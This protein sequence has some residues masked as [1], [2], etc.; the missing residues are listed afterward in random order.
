MEEFA[1][2]IICP[3]FITSAKEEHEKWESIYNSIPSID[4]TSFLPK[5]S[6]K[7]GSEALWE[8][9]DGHEEYWQALELFLKKFIE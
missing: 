7:H 2:E 1:Q 9:S 5:V 4:K 8:K 3:V 6:G